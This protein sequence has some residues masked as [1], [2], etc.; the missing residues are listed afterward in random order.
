MLNDKQKEYIIN[1]IENNQPI[2]E[3]MKYVLFPTPQEE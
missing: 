3:D 2:P 1:L